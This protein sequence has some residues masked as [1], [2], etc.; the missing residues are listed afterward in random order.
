METTANS[1]VVEA[2]LVHVWRR[3]FRLRRRR[4]G[5]LKLRPANCLTPNEAGDRLGITGEAIKQHIRNGN[6]RAAKAKNGFHWIRKED[7]EAFVAERQG[8][9]LEFKFRK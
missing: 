7:L 1:D 2:P 5:G 6:L 4:Y 9:E 3:R 8:R